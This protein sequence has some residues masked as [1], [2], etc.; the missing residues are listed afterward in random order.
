M[1]PH[2]PRTPPPSP[3]AQG[4]DQH[5]RRKWE[6]GLSN[7]LLC[8]DWPEPLAPPLQEA[9]CG[10]GEN[11]ISGDVEKNLSQSVIITKAEGSVLEKWVRRGW[12]RTNQALNRQLTHPPI[13]NTT[14]GWAV[15]QCLN[16]PPGGQLYFRGCENINYLILTL[17]SPNL[18]HSLNWIIGISG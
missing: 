11:H 9:P 8:A 7:S 5:Q 18:W 10:S 17:F 4:H 14:I 6:N 1:R 12:V 16:A 15:V 2:S 3:P 13:H